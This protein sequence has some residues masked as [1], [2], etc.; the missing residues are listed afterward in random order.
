MLDF[1]EI[2]GHEDIISHFKYSIKNNKISHA[3]LI[4]GEDDSGKMTLAK[5]FTMAL[6]CEGLDPSKGLDNIDSCGVCSS[7]KQLKTS[8]HPDVIYVTHEKASIGVGDVRDQVNNDIIIKPYSSQYKVYIIDEAEKLTIEA[9]NAL[10]KTLEEP[11][12]YALILL[13][14]NNINSLLETIQSRT[15]IMETKAID[16]DRIKKFLMVKHQIPD[17]QA[18]LSSI[19]A[20][21][22]IGKA[23]S[24]VSSERFTDIRD[25]ALN[26]LKN[27]NNMESYEIIST[28][29]DLDKNKDD[30]YNILDLVLLWYRDVLMYKVTKNPNLLLYKNEI[31]FISKQAKVISY[32]GIQNI[33]KLIEETKIKINAN[34]NLET[35]LQ[36]MLFTIKE[37]IN[38]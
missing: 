27:I 36:L 2:V 24:Y 22:N 23:I 32:E 34:V 1:K 25:S 26:I 28:I 29:G 9:Q 21:G 11:P 5:A 38:D 19:F 15:M 33:L 3:Y 35:T 16:K 6:Q 18:D 10:L 4:S 13:L 17:Y 7:C 37:N 30:I 8:N 12:D 14:S 20:Q 31:S